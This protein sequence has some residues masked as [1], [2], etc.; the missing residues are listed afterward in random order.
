METKTRQQTLVELRNETLYKLIEAQA[1]LR[2][3][4]K[5]AEKDPTKVVKEVMDP[6]TM[7]PR[8]VLI[9]EMVAKNKEAAE[10]WQMQLEALDEMIAE[11]AK[12]EDPK[13]VGVEH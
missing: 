9:G 13:A 12:A 8:Q 11:E 4:S 6:R 2:A 5:A 10:S 3:Q 7:Q 1:T